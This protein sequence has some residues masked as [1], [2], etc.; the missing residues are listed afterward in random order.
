MPPVYLDYNATT[1]IDPRVKEAMMPFLDTAFGNPSSSHWYGVQARQ[2]IEKARRQVAELLRCEPDEI[3][4]TS[5]GSESNNLAIKGAALS[6]RHKGSH[7]ITSQIEH[8]AVL[9][10]CRYLQEHGFTVTFL[11]VD[12]FGRID[13]RQLRAAIRG[14]TILISIMHANNEVGSIQPIVEIADIAHEYNILVHSDAAQSVGK[15]PVSIPDLGIDLLSI[16]GHKCYAPKGV[17]ALYVKRGV[18]LEK[19]MHG[20]DHEHHLRAGTENVPEIVGLG[21]AC[22]LI[23]N[24]GESDFEQLR[25]HRDYLE[26][27]LRDRIQ[28]LRINGHPEFRLPNTLSVSFQSIEANTIL[29]QLQPI[30]ASA[31][32]ACHTDDITI[33]HVLEAMQVPQDWAM[34]T[35]RLSVGRMTKQ[36]EVETAVT[37]IVNAVNALQGGRDINEPERGQIN[38]TRFTH[39]LGCACKLRPQAL[40]ALLQTLPPV[41]HEN[42]LVGTEAADDAAVYQ[43]DKETAWVQTVDFFTPIVDDPY[44]FGQIAAANSL[45]DIYAMGAQPLFGLNVVA[46][47][48]NRL[49]LHVLESILQGAADKASEA[50][51]PIAGGHTIDDTEP[52]YGL[53]VCG[54]VHPQRLWKNKGARPGDA[55]ILTKPI[56]LGI[57]TTAMKRHAVDTESAQTA[58]QTMTALNKQSAE[59][60][61]EYEIH[62]CT[63][64]TGFGL[65]GH[66]LEMLKASRMD[67]EI[68]AEKVPLLSR[69]LELSGAGIIPG[70]TRSNLDFVEPDMDWK[71]ALSPAYKAVLAD[72]QTSG[73]LLFA[74]PPQKP[75]LLKALQ[76]KGQAWEIG[77]IVRPGKGRIAVL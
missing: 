2:A 69:V 31:G 6:S 64:I 47:P 77:K 14:D 58:I 45:S 76:E 49:P 51:I 71:A 34:G 11:P 15:I 50:G 66:C 12:E 52:K 72:A 60:A 40:Q 75:S 65:L 39:G 5:G 37:E 35:L 36:A 62:A 23:L 1:P 43:I 18:L 55:L 42:I 57:L 17:G 74:A 22:E 27:G 3:V 13:S 56:G 33:S 20:A 8:P 21:C 44:D 54:R 61:I 25:K 53:V 9:Q 73:G 59:T 68:Y 28:H 30:A 41:Q 63:D 67:A 38:L 24:E 4:F 10:V 7:I 19:Q 46:F 26:S 32:A 48:S 70:G 29:D 16:A